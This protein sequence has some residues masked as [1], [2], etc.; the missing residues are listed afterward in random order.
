MHGTRLDMNM[1]CF[2][3][4]LVL[5]LNCGT[6]WRSRLQLAAPFGT[7]PLSSFPVELQ[8]LFAIL[9]RLACRAFEYLCKIDSNSLS[10]GLIPWDS[11]AVDALVVD[12]SYPRIST[13]F[14][15]YYRPY[16]AALHQVVE[17]SRQHQREDRPSLVSNVVLLQ[18]SADCTGRSSYSG[19]E[20]DR[21]SPRVRVEDF[22]K[23]VHWRSR[24][25]DSERYTPAWISKL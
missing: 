24:R 22:E 21:L 14:F 6:H 7:S 5:A 19:S 11:I 12:L 20:I 8:T 1:F 17:L 18:S 23:S 3:S 13:R 25:G 2:T 16:S 9:Q 4:N 10:C 15:G